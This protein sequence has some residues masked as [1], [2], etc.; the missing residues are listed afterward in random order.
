MKYI[1]MFENFNSFT[2]SRE[3]KYVVSYE[4]KI[5]EIIFDV[6]F[7]KNDVYYE[8]EYNARK[9]GEFFSL[10]NKNPLSIISTVTDITKDFIAE[11][12]PNIII[13]HHY[14]DNSPTSKKIRNT[15]NYRFDNKTINVRAKAN[16]RN[17]KTIKNY[18][19]DYYTTSQYNNAVLLIMHKQDVNTNYLI[20][21]SYIK[22]NL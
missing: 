11:Y 16:Y 13:I 10:V 20:D 15:N 3:D 9:N 22:I 21:K 2:K 8:R 19:L 12:N 14:S 17:L 5:E 4:F 7:K 6:H 18:I 1:K